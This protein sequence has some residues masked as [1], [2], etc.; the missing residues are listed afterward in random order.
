MNW[1]CWVAEILWRLGFKASY[2]TNIAGGLTGG[3][4][5]LDEYGFWQYPLFNHMKV[6][7][8][9]QTKIKEEER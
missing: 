6:D 8:S 1:K 2:S 5:E 4:G 7:S 3:Y 9:T